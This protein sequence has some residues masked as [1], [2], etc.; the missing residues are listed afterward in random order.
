MV[1]SII[2][3]NWK[4]S[5]GMP[6]DWRLRNLDGLSEERKMGVQPISNQWKRQ[7]INVNTK[8]VIPEGDRAF[9]PVRTSFRGPYRTLVQQQHLPI[10]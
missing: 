10:P 7:V 9:R 5:Y 1:V 2:E 6:V 3:P 8:T 4:T